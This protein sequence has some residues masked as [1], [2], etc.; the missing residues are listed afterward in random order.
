MEPAWHLRARLADPVGLVR[1]SRAEAEP[2]LN[3]L[4]LLHLEYVEGDAPQVGAARR[5]PQ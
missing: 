5:C 1:L 2:V 4:H 3:M